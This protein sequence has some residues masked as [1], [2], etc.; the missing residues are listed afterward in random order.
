MN[1]LRRT[2]DN[3]DRESVASDDAASLDLSDYLSESSGDLK[4]ASNFE[5]STSSM[6]RQE[7]EAMKAELEKKNQ[8]NESLRVQLAAA[9]EEMQRYVSAA[10]S[11]TSKHEEK[12]A[13]L[14]KK[15][16]A[17]NKEQQQVEAERAND[18][19]IERAI[20][21]IDYKSIETE[22]VQDFLTPKFYQ[23]LEYLKR[24]K[25]QFHKHLADKI[26]KMQFQATTNGYNVTILGFRE[27]HDA[28]KG[29][30][31]CIRQL[32]RLK[33]GAIHFHQ[34]KLNQKASLMKKN[35]SRVKQ[36]SSLWK[37]YSQTLIRLLDEKSNEFIKTFLDYIQ[38]V[39]KSLGEE[40]IANDLPTIRSEIRKRTDQF[41]KDN[42]LIKE[43]ETLKHQ[44]FEEFIKQNIIL[45]RNYHD[46]KPSNKS[47]SVLETLIDKVRNAFKTNSSLIGH[48]LKQFNQIPDLLQQVVIYYSCFNIQL[49]L[50]ESAIELLDKIERNTVTTVAT[51][52]G[53]GRMDSKFFW[54]T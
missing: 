45:Q 42:F 20:Q 36:K 44:G 50:Y 30:V 2:D 4:K 25:T 10:S 1:D 46:K 52:T 38:K 28:F 29:I 48:D 32:L 47:V 9:S 27:H 11:K 12:V 18:E 19:K 15:I 17:L 8:A 22:I 3:D 41:M 40:C 6:H 13:E 39:A 14:F 7:L 16:D 23:I 35:I 31:T 33:Q 53:S 37:Q 43:I 24:I 21:S 5:E 49:P 54:T 51:S 26:P 34:Q